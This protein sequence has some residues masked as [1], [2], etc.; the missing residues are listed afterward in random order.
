V[1]AILVTGAAGFIGSHLVDSLLADGERVVGVDNFHP[2]YAE[3]IKRRN[4]QGALSNPAFDLVEADVRD[5]EPMQE[6]MS[7]FAVTRVAH[8]AARAGVRPSLED[9]EGYLDTNLGGTL[10]VLRAAQRA[11]VQSFVFASSS[12]VYGAQA[13]VP[14]REDDRTDSPASPYAAT[15]KAAE[16]WCHC[17]HHLTGLPVACLRFFTVFGPRQR[18][19]LAIHKFTHLI[20]TG[21]AV[22]FFGDGTSSRDY[23]FVD[24]TISGVRA[25]LDR[26][27]EFQ[28]YNLGRSDPV[29]LADVV[30]TIERL[31][32]K[33]AI[34]DRQPDQPGDVPVT[35]ADVA[36][37]RRRLDYSP[38]V[39]FEEGMRRFVAWYLQEREQAGKVPVAA[40]R[41]R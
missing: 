18:P 8:L 3:R 39:S 34:L 10:A 25:A 15:K 41:T 9:P 32:G 29:T 13:R 19:D 24:D 12:S 40:T 1:S 27:D 17:H 16:V 20:D 2:F 38:R 35:C 4:L 30:A 14:F 36:K 33:A 37:A 6:V 22:P 23:T 21:Q 28:V 31:L 26:P 11:G 7:R 5:A